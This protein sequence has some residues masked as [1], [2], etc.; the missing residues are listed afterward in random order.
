MRAGRLARAVVDLHAPRHL[1][2]AE[3]ERDV[4]DPRRP[5]PGV[6]ARDDVAAADRVDAHAREVHRDPLPRGRALHGGVVHLDAA[7]ARAPARRQQR[8]AVAGAER[9][10][11]QRAR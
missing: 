10:R 7:H 3:L 2:V 6:L 4:E 5:Q 11:P 1:G 8:H 9:A